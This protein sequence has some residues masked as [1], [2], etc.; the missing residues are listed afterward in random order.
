MA[1]IINQRMVA[2]LD[3]DFVV[4]LIGMKINR[5]W[6][7]HKWLPVARAM[8]RMLAEVSAKPESGFLG[9]EAYGAFKMVLVQYWR[10]FEH[11]EAYAKDRNGEHYPAW[12]AF[13]ENMKGNSDVG[14]WH[15]TYKISSGGYEAFY[16]NMP[17]RGLGKIG[18]LVPATG[19]REYAAG[20]LVKQ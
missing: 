6:K 16:N 20:R 8:M 2:E 1:T 9:V 10:S 5:F 7:V 12:K 3:G 11:L 18:T 17:P 14:I 19:K 4:F 15:E 13:N